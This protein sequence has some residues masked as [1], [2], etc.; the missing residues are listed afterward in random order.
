[1]DIA[2]EIQRKLIDALLRSPVFTRSVQQV[3]KRVHTLQHGKAP[4]YH[5]PTQIEGEEFA[6]N[7]GVGR[8]FKFFWEELKSGHKPEPKAPQRGKP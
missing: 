7:G 4:E 5:N 3:H 8:F 2:D 6:G 1:V